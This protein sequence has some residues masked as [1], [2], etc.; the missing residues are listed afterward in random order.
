[1]PTYARADT[2]AHALRTVL[3]QTERDL[4]VVVQNNGNDPAT[5]AVVDAT[6]DPRVKHFHTDDVVSMVD[7][8][9]R[10]LDH[11]TGELITYIGDDDALLPDA[12]EAVGR[13]VDLTGAEIV[14][15]TPFLYLWPSY[16]HPRRRN[17]LHAVLT[18]DC[19]LTRESTREWLQRFYAFETEY[20][21][22]P[23]IY[24]SFVSRSV[25]ERVRDRYGKYFFGSLPDVTSGIINAVEVES[26]VKVS[27]PLAIA[28]IS[29]HSFGHK[30]SRDQH[31]LTREELELHF[32]ELLER[33]AARSGSD[34]VWLVSIEMALLEEQVLRERCPVLFERRRLAAAMAA[35]INESPSRYGETKALIEDLMR[36]YDIGAEELEIPVPLDAPPAPPDGVQLLGNGQVFVVLDCNPIGIRAVDDVVGLAAQLVPSLDAMTV[37]TPADPEHPPAEAPPPPSRLRAA[38]D[39][40]VRRAAV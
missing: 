13:A 24:N 19:V 2:L 28:G 31:H 23:M 34:L 11:C 8:W 17:R 4:E 15:S 29:G 33:P 36:E 32:P 16:W 22:L 18:F 7:N 27:R 3:E 40:I 20:S 14:S 12:C 9:E 25:V 39:A 30:L 26:F 38:V 6:G 1:M 21:Q 35:T 5:R 37:A 10:A